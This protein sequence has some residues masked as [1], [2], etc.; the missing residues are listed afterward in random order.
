MLHNIV[1]CIAYKYLCGYLSSPE[2]GI[3][4]VSSG[5]CVRHGGSP[6]K[7]DLPVRFISSRLF[8]QWLPP[9]RKAADYQF[10][11]CILSECQHRNCVMWQPFNIISLFALLISSAISHCR[12]AHVFWIRLCV[13]GHVNYVTAVQV[14]VPVLVRSGSADT[15]YRNT[16][17]M[18]KCPECVQLRPR[19]PVVT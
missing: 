6:S 16:L 4:P 13:R 3:N 17:L 1:P 7:G 2:T 12:P 19:A 14:W 15:W 10:W 11:Q 5:C 18:E 9:F 8:A